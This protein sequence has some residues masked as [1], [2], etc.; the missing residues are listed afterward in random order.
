MPKDFPLTTLNRHIPLFWKVVIAVALCEATGF[1]SGLLSM[2]G[3]G[4]WYASLAKPT[5]MP[6]SSVFAPVWITLYLMMGIAAGLVWHTRT[7]RIKEKTALYLFAVQL[8]L[9]FWWS[10]IF[11]RFHLAGWAFVEIILLIVAVLATISEFRRI[12]KIAA[13][14]MIPY[15]CWIS[16]AAILN[17]AIW[18]LNMD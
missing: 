8:F 14:L 2:P 4:A 15:L 13:G 12:N 11:F 9:N 5:W 16:F 1:A 6:P 3:M 17:A 18:Q 7:E 10:L